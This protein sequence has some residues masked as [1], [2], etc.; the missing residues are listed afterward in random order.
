[1]EVA[2][3]ADQLE[4]GL[5]HVREAPAD[6]GTVE[7]IVRRP[8]TDEREVLDE[9]VLDVEVGLVGDRWSRRRTPPNPDSQVT[10]IN[11]R[12]IELVAGGQEHWPPAG[13]QLY[14]TST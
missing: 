1:V 11:A 7:L 9:G 4:S 10:V 2:A 5:A 6:A 13:D 14:S 3:T 12:A 8:E